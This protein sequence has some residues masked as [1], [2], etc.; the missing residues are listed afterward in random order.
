MIDYIKNNNEFYGS[1][2][3]KKGLKQVGWNSKKSQWKRFEKLA[4]IGNLNNKIILD[5]GCGRGDF[6]RFCRKKN[7][8]FRSY[9]GVDIYK[10][11]F[12]RENKRIH[13]F[14]ADILLEKSI[15]QYDYVIASGLF[16]LKANQ[17]LTKPMIKRCFSLC[18]K[19]FAFNLPSDTTAK[20]FRNPVVVYYGAY[21][22]LKY[23]K[24]LCKHTRLIQGYLPHDFTVY[25][26]KR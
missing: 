23:C 22:M 5:V 1:I 26:V 16:N 17:K 19:G 21:A 3:H 6:V 24:A 13:F 25:M 9:T 15:H 18:R 11:K 10:Y 12:I 7:I 14:V 8:R 4:E 2:K 20:K